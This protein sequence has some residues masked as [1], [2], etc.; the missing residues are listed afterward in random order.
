MPLDVVLAGSSLHVRKDFLA[1][2][3]LAG[4]VETLKSLLLPVFPTLAAH[5]RIDMIT[6]ACIALNSFAIIWAGIF[7]YLSAIWPLLGCF[8]LIVFGTAAMSI[9]SKK[10]AVAVLNAGQIICLTFIFSSTGSCQTPMRGYLGSIIVMCF[11]LTQNTSFSLL[12]VVIVSIVGIT[13]HADMC[14]DRPGLISSYH[15]ASLDFSY[16]AL[17]LLLSLLCERERLAVDATKSKFVASVT[18]ELR[19]PL[20]GI[21][22]AAELLLE[23]DSCNEEELQHVGT[24]YGCGQLLSSLINNVLDAEMVHTQRRYAGTGR[25]TV[26]DAVEVRIRGDH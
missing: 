12:W 19:T 24:V 8:S 5:I 18:H 6:V 14:L 1:S 25:E 23:S 7:Y 4:V 9:S 26:F 11:I 22:C 20:N 2:G 16:T 21:L 13:I 15:I 3:S 17:V 10:I